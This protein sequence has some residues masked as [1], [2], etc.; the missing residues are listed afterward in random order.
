[1]VHVNSVLAPDAL[2]PIGWVA[3]GDP[4]EVLPP[5]EHDAIWA[6][7]EDSTSQGPSSDW[8]AGPPGS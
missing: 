3:V 6:I 1:M 8:S 2:V 7:Q 4:A 5:G